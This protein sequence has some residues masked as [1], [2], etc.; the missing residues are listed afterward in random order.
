MHAPQSAIGQDD[1]L[2]NRPNI[3]SLT[4]FRF[5]AAFLVV[6]AHF[7]NMHLIKAGYPW[8]QN[9]SVFGSTGMTMFFVLSGFVIQYNYAD[10]FGKGRAGELWRF[11]VARF[12][13]LYPLFVFATALSIAAAPAMQ[14]YQWRAL[15][16]WLT[17]THG[18]LPIS[19]D[20]LFPGDA[21]TPG[22]W[23]ISVEVLLYII[24]IPLT[25]VIRRRATDDMILRTAVAL[26][27]FLFIFHGIRAFTGYGAEP[28]WLWYRSAAARLPE[29]AAGMIAAEM[30][31][32]RSAKSAPDVHERNLILL[33][34]AGTFGIVAAILAGHLTHPRPVWAN[35]MSQNWFMAPFFAVFLYAIAR[36][37][38]RL[39]L[40]EGKAVLALGDAS[41][42]IYLLHPPILWMVGWQGTEASA[43]FIAFKAVVSATAITLFS[44]GVYQYF[45]RPAREIIRSA[46]LRPRDV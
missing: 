45:E 7:S 22:S 46:L 37:N 26:A 11:A 43:G 31:M 29:F 44:L 3:P 14:G 15:P 13:R 12:A 38:V 41:Y 32:R 33:L 40:L 34:L 23:S 5:Y 30:F 9:G 42:S 10:G 6:M 8:A 1:R 25:I 2:T 20:G 28:G 17:M 16:Y 4:G 24:F 18:W 27:L 19:I 35:A 21:L 36:F 39:Q